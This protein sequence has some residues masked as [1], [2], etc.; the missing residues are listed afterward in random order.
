ML[1]L[2]VGLAVA[3]PPAAAARYPPVVVIVFDEFPV[4]S[5]LRPDGRIDSV[6]YPGFGRLARQ[7]T[8]FPNAF[9]AQDRTR[10]A[11][12]AI[13]DGRRPRRGT[14]PTSADHPSNLFSLLSSRGYR[15]EASEP[16]TTLCPRAICPR[17][18]RRGPGPPP[19]FLSRRVARFRH[20]VRSIRRT[21]RPQLLFHHQI[22]PHVPWEFL[23]SGRRYREDPTPWYRGLSSLFGFHD[24]FLTNQNQQRHLLQVGFVDREIDLLLSRLERV[25]LL[26]RALLVVTADHGVGFDLSVPDRRSITPGNVDEV[27]PVPFFVKRP[28]Q[29]KGRVDRA[30]VH[31]V[32][33]VPTIA[34]LLNLGRLWPMTGRSALRRQGAHTV[35][36]PTSDLNGWVSIRPR[37]LAKARAVN[38]RQKARLFGTGTD[39]L[40]RLGP[41]RGLL[42]RS[43]AGFAIQPAGA[44]ATGFVP[45]VDFSASTGDAPTWFTGMLTAD[46]SAGTT[47]ELALA[48]N[49]RI[50]AVGR[51]FRLREDT[52]DRFSLLVPEAQL[53]PGRNE[54]SLFIVEDGRLV[55]V[56]PD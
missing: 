46:S 45:E 8:W 29:S 48:L 49:G 40:Y 33:V 13:L 15:V 14:R 36:I 47:R 34:D 25:G 42:G 55:R 4:D 43:L 23:P 39:S 11:L 32:D 17:S 9:S 54:A 26:R 19:F 51:A 7:S 52:S 41:N 38:R 30:F 27:A 10:V 50:A 56:E 6:R 18:L 24:V 35:R 28:G 1:L 3:A 12:P 16:V 31:T 2:A 44:K 22:L 37:A 20:M 53:R 21:R 5:L